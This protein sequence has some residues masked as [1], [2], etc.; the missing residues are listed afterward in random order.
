M[1]FYYTTPL[2]NG[3]TIYGSPIEKLGGR[4]V[5]CSRVLARLPLRLPL[6]GSRKKAAG[7]DLPGIVSVSA[8]LPEAENR[9]VSRVVLRSCK[10]QDAL[11][12][13][14]ESRLQVAAVKPQCLLVRRL[15]HVV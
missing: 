1:K 12:V 14:Q 9:S 3:E 10:K 7:G 6:G 4:V 13:G 8:R 15:P 2:I 5:W 11:S